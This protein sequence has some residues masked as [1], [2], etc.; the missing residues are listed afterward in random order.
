LISGREGRHRG[1]ACGLNEWQLL[2]GVGRPATMI[3][4]S[5][6]RVLFAMTLSVAGC[7]A[8]AGASL[9]P[10]GTPASATPPTQISGSPATPSTAPGAS[11]SV[12]VSLA[13]LP[14][15][16]TIEPVSASN[17]SAEARKVLI[18]CHVLDNFGLESVGGM[19]VMP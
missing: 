6:L 3:K 2:Q 4:A 15:E 10:A 17:P 11:P 14:I 1:G 16:P 9:T 13:A 8:T 5:Y 7:T 19:A 12:D 18:A